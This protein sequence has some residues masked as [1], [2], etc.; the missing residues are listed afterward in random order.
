MA[1]QNRNQDQTRNERDRNQSGQTRPERGAQQ[2]DRDAA[3]NRDSNR[4][5]NTGQ[6]ERG[7]GRPSIDR[8]R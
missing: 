3:D 6:S 1:D 2:I 5:G 7:G 8:D 4:P